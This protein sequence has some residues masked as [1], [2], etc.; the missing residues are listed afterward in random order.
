MSPINV[1]VVGC[2]MLAR[3]AHIPN[4][5]LE[6]FLDQIETGG[7]PVCGVDDAVRATRVAFASI[8]AADEKRSV[9][10]EEV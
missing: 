7:P 4:I 2:G 1:A 3:M 5:V 8:K 6:R 10:L 9:R